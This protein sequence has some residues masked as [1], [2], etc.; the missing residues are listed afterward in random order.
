MNWLELVDAGPGEGFRLQ[1]ADGQ[2]IMLGLDISKRGDR[3][4]R[5][6]NQVVLITSNEVEN[7]I[8]DAML[9]LGKSGLY[10]KK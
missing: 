4:I 6:D 1:K 2:H 3:V 9:D 5:I 7:N 10:L 8:G